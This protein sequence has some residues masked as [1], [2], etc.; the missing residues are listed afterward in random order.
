MNVTEAVAL[1]PCI[2][3]N[4]N[5]LKPKTEER[6]DSRSSTIT[7]KEK[8]M[9]KIMSKTLLGSILAFTSTLEAPEVNLQTN[10]L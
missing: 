10:T 7:K 9:K 4:L 2:K 6:K 1:E 5:Q 8:R 3:V